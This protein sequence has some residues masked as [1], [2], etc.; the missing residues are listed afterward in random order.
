[1]QLLNRGPEEV[2]G[3]TAHITD[4]A[5]TVLCPPQGNDLQIW[6]GWVRHFVLSSLE[7]GSAIHT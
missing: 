3:S 1:M 4:D 2:Q 5:V 6:V 7:N